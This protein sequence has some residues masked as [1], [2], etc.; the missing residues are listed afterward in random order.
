MTGTFM[1]TVFPSYSL[2]IYAEESVSILTSGVDAFTCLLSN[3]D[4]RLSKV[5]KFPDFN[6]L[7]APFSPLLPMHSPD[8]SMQRAACVAEGN[9]APDVRLSS[10]ILWLGWVHHTTHHRCQMKMLTTGRHFAPNVS[11]RSFKIRIHETVISNV[12]YRN[13]TLTTGRGVS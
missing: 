11:Y 12:T 13:N 1:T 9:D 4:A 2:M 6:G 5:A 10:V 3:L 8:A 7:I